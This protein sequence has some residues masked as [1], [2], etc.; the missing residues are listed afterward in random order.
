[1]KELTK[2]FGAFAV[3]G[4]GR[5]H[6]KLKDSVRKLRTNDGVHYLVETEGQIC[7]RL[8]YTPDMGTLKIT[9][10]YSPF[11]AQWNNLG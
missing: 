1:M 6:P 3:F 4:I 2:L 10:A 11:F 7:A 5:R 9:L 8:V